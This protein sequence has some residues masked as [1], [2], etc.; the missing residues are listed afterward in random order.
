MFSTF[1]FPFCL[2][3]TWVFIRLSRKLTRSRLRN[4][5]AQHLLLCLVR[6]PSDTRD[7]QSDRL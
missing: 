1:V 3:K 5:Q 6:R 7:S 4:L 2:M